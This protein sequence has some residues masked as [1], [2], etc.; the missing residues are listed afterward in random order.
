MSYIPNAIIPLNDTGVEVFTNLGFK[1]V[2]S[3]KVYRVEGDDIFIRVGYSGKFKT[4]QEELNSWA[5]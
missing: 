4:S 2:K 5:A 3:I 1:A